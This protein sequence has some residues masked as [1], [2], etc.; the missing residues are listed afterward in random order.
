MKSNL[1]FLI[2]FVCVFL[3][4]TTQAADFVNL[5]GIPGL[6]GDP[7]AGGLNDYI[8]ALYRLSISIAALLAVIKIVIAGAKYMLTD[9]VPAK[10]EAK[11]DIQGALIGLLI[12]IGAIIILNTVNT[13]LTNLD[14]SIATTTVQQGTP[15]EEVIAQMQRDMAARA[16]AAGSRVVLSECESFWGANA[17]DMLPGES[18]E[19]ACERVCRTAPANGGMGGRYIDNWNLQGESDQCEYVESE[20][21]TCNVNGSMTCCEGINDGTW[22]VNHRICQTPENPFTVEFCGTG[23]LMTT[24]ADL[25]Q[26]CTAAGNRVL[27]VYTAPA[28]SGQLSSVACTDNSAAEAAAAEA[29]NI[30][31]C[32]NQE[33]GGRWNNALNVCE[34][35]PAMPNGA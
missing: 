35:G 15:V 13:D 1:L 9:I 24:C 28:D 11:K 14:L 18:E 12:V 33:G 5:V 27:G 19:Q 32:E 26:Q 3:P 25:Q 2:A 16:A 17:F 31:A 23:T 22:A 8:N 21:A 29:A 20:A 6:S 7:T 34:T 4:F 30:E 10:E